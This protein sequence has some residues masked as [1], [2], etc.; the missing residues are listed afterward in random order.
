[1]PTS[2]IPPGSRRQVGDLRAYAMQHE[3]LD[4]VTDLHQVFPQVLDILMAVVPPGDAVV[5]MIYQPVHVLAAK[6]QLVVGDVHEAAPQAVNGD[7]QTR[8]RSHPSGRQDDMPRPVQVGLGGGKHV[9]ASFRVG[10]P[11]SP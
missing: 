6:L 7:L 8:P 9:D 1:M 5:D 10:G 2:T 11:S 4:F 3:P